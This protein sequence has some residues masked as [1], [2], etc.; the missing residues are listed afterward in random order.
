MAI[1]PGGL[2]ITC[3]YG[4]PAKMLG[5]SVDHHNVNGLGVE[6]LGQKSELSITINE[7]DSGTG[8]ATT[9]NHE[10]ELENW[11]TGEKQV[12]V[13]LV[14]HWCKTDRQNSSGVKLI[15]RDSSGAKLIDR[16]SSGYWVKREGVIDS[17]QC[18]VT[19]QTALSRLQL[20]VK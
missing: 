10:T 20:C 9:P 18:P 2:K 16:D 17:D 14:K 4:K 6:R 12:N 19:E 5:K 8:G 11:M 1:W 7:K 13:N 3:M 15:D